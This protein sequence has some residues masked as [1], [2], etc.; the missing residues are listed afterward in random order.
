MFAGISAFGYITK[1]NLTGVGNFMLMGLWGLILASIVNIFM[2][3]PMLYWGISIFGVVI[4]TG[5]TAYDVQ[6]IKTLNVIG[7]AGTDDDHKEAIHGAPHPLSRTSS[8]CLSTCYAASTV[9]LGCGGGAR[10]LRLTRRAQGVGCWGV[11]G[12]VGG[13]RPLPGV[14]SGG[15]GRAGSRWSSGVPR[16]RGGGLWWWFWGLG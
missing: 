16:C 8:T 5:L 11:S 13:L 12:R 3:S 2:Q 14:A 15:G 6:K 4:F 9:A 10:Q 7:N 1:R